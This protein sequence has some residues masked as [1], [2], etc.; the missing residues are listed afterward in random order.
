MRHRPTKSVITLVVALLLAAVAHPVGIARA[1]APALTLGT[2]AI[3]CDVSDLAIDVAGSGFTPGAAIALGIALINQSGQPPRYTIIGHA[4]ADANGAF[5]AQ[6][7]LRGNVPCPTRVGGPEATGLPFSVGA[8]MG[9][10]GAQTADPPLATAPLTVTVLDQ[11]CDFPGPYCISGRFLSYWQKH[12]GLMRFGL[13]LSGEGRE[14]LEDGNAYIVQY[15]ERARLELH[16]ENADTPYTILVGQF[17]RRVQAE[18]A[19]VAEPFRTLF[20]VRQTIGRPLTAATVVQA[21]YLTFERGAL[22]YQPDTRT[23]H[24]FDVASDDTVGGGYAA[25]PDTWTPDQAV[26]GGLGPSPDLYEPGH[27]FGKLWRENPEVRARLGYATAPTETA[28]TLTL[29]TFA[30]VP[31]SRSGV[32]LFTRPFAGTAYAV[33]Q[34]TY[35][36]IL[37]R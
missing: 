17:G 8:F 4:N 30:T 9:D 20:I 12:G 6:L 11:R 28:Y 32:R 26:G 27:G 19:L 3:A 21:T 37:L 34:A 25:F 18:N 5:T 33:N 7:P 14:Q 31:L 2:G 29:Q 24:L 16:P 23:I 22:L 10:P 15:F 36:V 1:A 35:N 13:P